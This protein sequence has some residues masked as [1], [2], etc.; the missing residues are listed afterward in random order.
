MLRRSSYSPVNEYGPVVGVIKEIGETAGRYRRLIVRV[1]IAGSR[2]DIEVLADRRVTDAPERLPVLRILQEPDWRGI[3]WD[4]VNTPRDETPW[5]ALEADPARV[6][7][8]VNADA[9]DDPLPTAYVKLP[10][11]IEVDQ[12]VV[13]GRVAGTWFYLSSDVELLPES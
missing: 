7:T 2:R 10:P 3:R 9:A 11:V 6:P 1:E 8:G 4:D 5:E 13:I 12:R